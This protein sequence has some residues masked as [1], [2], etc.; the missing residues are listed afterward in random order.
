MTS[1]GCDEEEGRKEGKKGRKGRKGR[2]ERRPNKVPAHKQ[3][4]KGATNL[5]PNH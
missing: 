2:K 1:I 3:V 4:L 5:V